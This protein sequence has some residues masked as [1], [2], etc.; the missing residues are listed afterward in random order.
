MV[1]DDTK[2]RQRQHENDN[3]DH[4]WSDGEGQAS[5]QLS[6]LSSSVESRRHRRVTRQRHRGLANED[7]NVGWF[8]YLHYSF[9][10]ALVLCHLV[11]GLTLLGYS[12]VIFLNHHPL[13]QQNW[14][15]FPS[16]LTIWSSLFLLAGSTG[17]HG[18]H[19][20][21]CRRYG[22]NISAYIGIGLVILNSAIL[23]FF[24]IRKPAFLQ[25]LRRRE[26]EFYLTE[27]KITTFDQ[28]STVWIIVILAFTLVEF[29]RL[30]MLRQL[31][32]DLLVNDDA[33]LDDQLRNDVQRRNLDIRLWKNAAQS[34]NDDET[35]LSS[36]PLLMDDNYEDEND[37]RGLHVKKPVVHSHKEYGGGDEFG[38]FPSTLWWEEPDSESAL[39]CGNEAAIY[40]SKDA[41]K[42]SWWFS[43]AWRSPKRNVTNTKSNCNNCDINKSHPS[44]DQEGSLSS[45]DFAP[46]D[47]EICMGSI[48]NENEPDL[49]WA[50]D[51]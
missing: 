39:S 49:S 48:G 11:I 28:N 7:P 51:N 50:Q 38:G 14:L 36:Q 21:L 16:L 4:V 44:Q 26:S 8:H 19:S 18:L 45:N 32:S 23:I 46:V 35:M 27:Q 3:N 34:G 10:N 33:K 12:V 41:N 40:T 5:S 9:S 24:L 31:R 13:Q 37:E 25:Y 29:L 17:L 47:E 15:A 1:N 20:P 30:Y 43:N 2:I 22:L 6:F 42:K